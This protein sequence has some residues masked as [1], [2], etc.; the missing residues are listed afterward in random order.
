[1]RAISK[2]I[3]LFA[4]GALTFTSCTTETSSAENKKQEENR[5][6]NEAPKATTVANNIE[7]YRYNDQE[8]AT[9]QLFEKAKTSVAFITTSNLQR[10]YWTRD[11]QEIKSGTGSAFVWDK[12]GH[13]VTNYHVI[14]GAD[15]ATVTM[16]DQT[17]Y[18][19]SLV[20]IAPDKD[21]AVL[22]IDAQRNELFPLPK[23]MSDNLK[24]GQSTYAI[25]NPFGLDQTLTTGIISALGREIQSVSGRPIKNV[26]QTDAAINP[27]N[28]GGPLL[29]SQGELIGVNTAIY[30]PSGA[31]A[32]IGFSIPVDEVSW[33]VPDLINYGEIRR[34]ILGVEL[35][36][37]QITNQFKI[38]GALVINVVP[39]SGS[40]RAGLLG[41][42]RTR[43]GEISW[44]DVIVGIEGKEIKS[45]YDLLEVL[46][47]FKPGDR[48]RV[49]AYRGNDLKRFEVELGSSK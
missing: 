42:K 47:T 48:V 10:D 2:A 3:F 26:I 20:G 25:G 39:G 4:I 8:K 17:T 49:E 18:Q 46:E 13:I 37:K 11:L 36:T 44:G 9:I 7:G 33:V 30:S 16:S 22:K 38:D 5:T 29:N 21:L 27:G 45:N 6:F 41:T 43:S 23:G 12:E 28:S 35:A 15:R 32:G 14:K 31:Y 40:A 24:V 19:A 34:P 1:M